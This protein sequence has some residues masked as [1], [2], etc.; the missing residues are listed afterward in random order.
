[1]N[2][3]LPMQLRGKGAQFDAG[4]KTLLGRHAPF[5]FDEHPPLELHDLGPFLHAN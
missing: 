2:F 5:T 3:A 1:V 4:L